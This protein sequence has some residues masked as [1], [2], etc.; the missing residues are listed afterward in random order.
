MCGNRAM[1]AA[2]GAQREALGHHEAAALAAVAE[3]QLIA[4]REREGEEHRVLER[5]LRRGQQQPE[6]LERLAQQ[7]S[8]GHTWKRSAAGTGC[9]GRARDAGH[10]PGYDTEQRQHAAEQPGFL[11]QPQ[12]AREVRHLMGRLAAMAREVPPR[13]AHVGAIELADA[14]VRQPG[15]GAD[16]LRARLV[17]QEAQCQLHACALAVVTVVGDAH[18]GILVKIHQNA[19]PQ[20][21][22][23]IPKFAL[24]LAPSSATIAARCWCEEVARCCCIAREKVAGRTMAPRSLPTGCARVRSIR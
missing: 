5:D 16:G 18:E 13:L 3:A 11:L 2:R 4:A 7:H 10:S 21:W 6:S 24:A 17:M 1:S 23:K 14:I 8:A 19:I 20:N 12:R 15:P 22:L 9:G